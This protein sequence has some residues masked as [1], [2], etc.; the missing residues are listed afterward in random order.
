MD[1]QSPV[2]G[3]L[4]PVSSLAPHYLSGG[5]WQGIESIG[6]VTVNGS[7]MPSSAVSVTM[8]FSRT[9]DFC[10]DSILKT[11]TSDDGEIIIQDAALWLFEVPDQPLVIAPGMWYWMVRVT[12]ADGS[13]TVIY[14]GSLIVYP[15]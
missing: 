8:E 2:S 15:A 1:I 10:E 11:L 4:R 3:S 12:A 14:V 6:P 13:V 9:A 5:P 7:P